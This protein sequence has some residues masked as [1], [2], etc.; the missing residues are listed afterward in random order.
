MWFKSS[1]IRVIWVLGKSRFPHDEQM[2]S[3][4][5]EM[6]GALRYDLMLAAV[7]LFATVI[8][9]T[10]HELYRLRCLCFDDQD[11]GVGNTCTEIYVVTFLEVHQKRH[12]HE[13]NHIY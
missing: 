1:K 5:M 2:F 11:L 10:Q 3:G 9:L 4:Q 12:F 6:Q 13:P 8:R 7:L